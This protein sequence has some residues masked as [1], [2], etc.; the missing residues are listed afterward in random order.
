MKENVFKAALAGL[1]HDIGKFA[2]R[3]GE[4]GSRIW[5]DT[6]R[7]D[8]K[9]QH[10]LYSGDFV[11]KYVPKQW[12]EGL[13]GPARHHQPLTHHDQV[14]ALADH[15]S[16]GERS[17]S[18]EKLPRQLQ[19]IFCSISGSKD[20]AGNLISPPTRKYLPLKKLAIRR[21]TIFPVDT[22]DDSHGTY[23]E[24]WDGFT[25]EATALKA[26]FE[27]EG[28]NPEAYLES[29]LNQMQQY[30]WCI[31]SAYYRSIPDV[32]LYDHSRMTAALAA[33]LVEH[34]TDKIQA[35]LKQQRHNEP[36]ALLVGGDISG[37][38]KFIYTITSKGA[39]KSLRGRSFYLQ[40]LTEVVAR[41]VLNQL[42]L[43]ITNLLYAGG[44]NFFLLA[45]AE[46]QKELAKIT[47]DV[48]EKLLTS[49]DGALH[50]IMAHHAISPEGFQRTRFHTEWNKLHQA[51]IHAKSQP[52]GSL[53]SKKLAEEVGSALG[54][55]GDAN[56][57]CQVC[58]RETKQTEATESG[59]EIIRICHLCQSLADLGNK[60]AKATHLIFA[61]TTPRYHP[62]INHWWQGVE[63]FGSKMWPVNANL[64]PEPGRPYLNGLPE[65]SYLLEV[66]TLFAAARYG[67]DLQDEINKVR[68]AKLQ[69]N[70]LFAQLVARDWD[71]L[72]LT[73]DELAKNR[74]NA[75][76]I[77]HNSQQTEDTKRWSGLRRWGVLRMDVDNLGRLFYEGFVDKRGEN[78]LTLSRLASLSF[79]LRL[80][81]EGWLP[82]LGRPPEASPRLVNRLYAQYAGGDDVFIVGSW[83]ALPEF[84]AKIRVS[85][86]EYAC[87]NPAVTLSGG[88]TLAPE[89]YPL[90]QAANE[91]EQ[92][93]KAA[94]HYREKKDAFC[95]LG[96]VTAW[97]EFEPL[98]RRAYQFADWCGEGELVSRAL[99]QTLLA[100]YNE[101]SVGC[102]EALRT[103]K[104]QPGQIYYGP[105]M[106]HLA[107]QLGRRVQELTRRIENQNTSSQLRSQL[108]NIR[109]ELMQIERDMLDQRKIETIGLAARW[110][111]YLIR[112]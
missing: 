108:E 44:G 32:S 107:Y 110:A 112:Q 101:Y 13:S 104:W 53:N 21:D 87:Y 62:K 36:V 63:L 37:V 74:T 35:W 18:G 47:S 59:G 68:V 100:I 73:F 23:R 39:A 105:W 90:Y 109:R 89:K 81:F 20:E 14:V 31:P 24:L 106:W 1:L 50:L 70:R 17:D 72:P 91:A 82:Q 75:D 77:P 69:S 27:V 46:Q 84:A 2:Q 66:H 41:Y 55:G 11:E 86:A 8:Y 4:L 88:V 38:Q 95:F 51:L 48:T 34:S 40:L 5:D 60:L 96:M 3:A 9:Y 97:E 56:S 54:V 22:I 19:S 42:G 12:R 29:L 80:F 43:P 26:A 33:C 111:Q 76:G 28:A 10:A 45:G 103:G 25:Q 83:D 85:L 30:T 6:A 67:P 102:K 79:A 94:K 61:Y 99:L 16:A 49:H 64:P 7:Q 15:L 52:L 71:D 93:E 92:A 57:L 65:Q 98:M 58:G 78:S